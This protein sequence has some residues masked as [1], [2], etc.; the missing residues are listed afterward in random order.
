MHI[1][2]LSSLCRVFL[3]EQ[4]GIR[5]LDVVHVAEILFAVRHGKLHS[6][7]VDVQE[8]GAVEAHR[9][10]VIALEDVQGKELRRPLAWRKG[11]CRSDSRDN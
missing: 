3:G 2:K 7:D 4:P 1:D 9:P 11:S 6:L 8:V 10:Q 5:N